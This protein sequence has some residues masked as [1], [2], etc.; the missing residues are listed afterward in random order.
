MPP[1]I[2]TQTS[3]NNYFQLQKDIMEE[4]KTSN[5]HEYIDPDYE[6][7]IKEIAEGEVILKLNFGSCL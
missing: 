4:H 7:R 1:R 3:S 6:I 5:W 2:F